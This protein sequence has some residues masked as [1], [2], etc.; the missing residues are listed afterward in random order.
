MAECLALTAAGKVK[1]EIELA[2]LG[3]I[4]DI[5]DRLAH[6]KVAARVVIDFAP[7]KSAP[8][9]KTHAALAGAAS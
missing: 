2:P 4:N 9:G 7:V 5:F 1:A 3:S 6:D 8:N